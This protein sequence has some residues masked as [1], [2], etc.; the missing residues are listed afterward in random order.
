MKRVGTSCPN[1]NVIGKKYLSDKA[2]TKL[3]AIH[4]LLLR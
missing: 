2:T 3:G 1:P 4:E